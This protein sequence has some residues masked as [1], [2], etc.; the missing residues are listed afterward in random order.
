MLPASEQRPAPP[1]PA[2][3]QLGSEGRKQS[4]PKPRGP[5]GSGACWPRPPQPHPS[6]T[7]P[8]G[9]IHLQG[10]FPGLRGRGG[11]PAVSG[12]DPRGCPEPNAEVRRGGEAPGA[13]PARPRPL[14]FPAAAEVRASGAPP[15]RGSP[16]A[17]RLPLKGSPPG[18]PSLPSLSFL[19]PSIS[20]SA[21]LSPA[22]VSG[23]LLVRGVGRAHCLSRLSVLPRL[24][25]S[26]R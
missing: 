25:V 6:P 17:P 20:L 11:G 14:A 10:K 24:E 5:G 22:E 3:S 1:A 18:S 2:A 12:P 4:R 21:C 16:A 19:S 7:R 8:P 23:S 26:P 13:P 9:R 15:A